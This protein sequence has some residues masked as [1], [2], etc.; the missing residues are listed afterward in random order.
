[1]AK[2]KKLHTTLACCLF[3][4]LVL[5]AASFLRPR[6]IDPDLGLS[7]LKESRHGELLGLSLEGEKQLSQAWALW[8]QRDQ[9][10]IS[11]ELL[12]FLNKPDYEVRLFAVRALSKLEH[13]AA[14]TPIEN[15]RI[16]Q[17]Q[18]IRNW[19]SAPA[20]RRPAVSPQ[21]PQLTLK[22]ALA[23]IRSRNL[24]GQAKVEAISREIGIPWPKL[25]E[26]SRMINGKHRFYTAG[27]GSQV[28]W[29][30]VD[31]LYT[32]KRRSEDIDGVATDLVL[33]PT[34]EIRLKGA[35][36]PEKEEAE[37]L[38]D[39]V[40]PLRALTPETMPIPEYLYVLGQPAVEPVLAR[41]QDMKDHPQSYNN[42]QGYS[43]LF[44]AAARLADA[45]ALPLLQHFE[46]SKTGWV[47]YYA[48]QSLY[49]L[50]QNLKR[51]EPMPPP[52]F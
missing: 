49:F 3:A 47:G 50:R 30:I 13:P 27:V 52:G 38:L 5:G 45:R 9:R 23:R 34:Q 19:N 1:M 24:K 39:Y 25:V 14:Q 15:L 4:V 37:L 29:E 18:E 20:T 42:T 48:N 44:R 43:H 26:G 31:V 7:H 36:L 12:P 16:K 28:I 51:K 11:N 2:N 8:Q 10:D 41:L 6:K 33:N 46:K 35:A 21:I 32:M 40:M 17:Q 22:L